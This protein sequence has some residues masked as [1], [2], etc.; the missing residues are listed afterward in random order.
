[1]ML[2]EVIFPGGDGIKPITDKEVT[3]FPEPDSPTIPKVSPLER[4]RLRLDTAVKR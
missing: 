3:D 1:M 2:P 4:V